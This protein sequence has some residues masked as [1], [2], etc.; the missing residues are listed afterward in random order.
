ML[1]L[2][3]IDGTLIRRAGPHHRD[4]LVY[5]VREV[6][7]VETRNDNISL[8]GKLD[9]H[10]L[11]E[12]MTN[13]GISARRA[14]AALPDIYRIAERRYIETVPLLRRKA[15]PGARHL[16]SWL[17]RRGALLGLVTGNL[18]RI[19]WKKLEQAGLSRYFRFGAFG[20]M[21]PTRAGLARL[22]LRRAAEYGWSNGR[23]TNIHGVL[24]GDTPSDVAAGR[25]A[26][27]SAIAV[28]TGLSSREEL[29]ASKPTLCSDDF[30]DPFLREWFSRLLK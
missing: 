20:E 26:R 3:D 24:I 28:A 22:A 30:R 11:M 27:L 5:A 1:V 2:F 19:G 4:A 16:L 21:A 25:A 9:P 13:A 12:M 14:R 29:E 23:S 6:L 8:H 17:E 18:E 15:C 7:S 10:I